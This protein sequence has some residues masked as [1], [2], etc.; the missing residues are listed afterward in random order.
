MNK[1]KESIESKLKILEKELALVQEKAASEKAE[2]EKRQVIVATKL[3][4][5][6]QR[7]ESKQHYATTASRAAISIVVALET[8]RCKTLACTSTFNCLAPLKAQ[9]RGI[10]KATGLRL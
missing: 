10:C 6:F 7:V 2:F 1:G 5:A 4:R 3:K 9:G 8:D